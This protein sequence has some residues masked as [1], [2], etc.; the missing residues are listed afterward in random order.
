MAGYRELM[1]NRI[2][3]GMAAILV[4]GFVATSVASFLVSRETIRESILQN[5]LPLTSDN[6]YSEIQKDLIRPVFVSSVMA[7][8]TFLRDWAL[9]GEGNVDKVVKYLRE[10][11]HE[12]DAVTAFFIS[13]RTRNYYHPKGIVQRVRPDDPEDVWYFRAR[14]LKD[15]YEVNVDIDHANNRAWTIFINYRVLD[16]DGRFIGV[17]G[18]GLTAG[19]VRDLI[20]G[21]RKKFGRT[22]YFLDVS[23]AVQSLDGSGS[24]AGQVGYMPGFET[25]RDQV[26][27]VDNGS[28]SYDSPGGRYLV[29]S[30]FI[31]ELNWFLVV[32]QEER[33]VTSNIRRTLVVNLAVCG[34]IVSVVL[35]GVGATFGAY[36]KRLVQLATHDELTGLFN[37]RAFRPMLEQAMAE[38]DRTGESLSVILF[39]IDLFKKI[40]DVHGHQIGDDVIRVVGEGARRAIRTADTLCRWGGEEFLILLRRCSLPDAVEVADKVRE[41]IAGETVDGV[42]ATVS[43][44]ASSHRRG[45]LPE[46][47]LAR[48]D[49]AMYMAKRDGRNTVRSL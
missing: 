31:P 36:R 12:Y 45:E 10:I 4:L 11:Q 1:R 47:F 41:E 44:G 2:I 21:Y 9:A 46:A 32:E 37:R 19:S 16:Y 28:F 15:P 7:A 34:I 30:R 40:N 8:D 29:N 25:I 22:V 17:T 6:I 14:D 23:G 43:L 33:V 27:S 48:V 13:E 39:D 26:V 38:A 24:P 20:D 18:V 5:E 3:L 35:A 42:S 49:Q